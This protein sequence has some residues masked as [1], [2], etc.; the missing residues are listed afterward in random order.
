MLDNAVLHIM[1]QATCTRVLQ[2]GVDVGQLVKWHP[3]F[4]EVVRKS[5]CSWGPAMECH[6]RGCHLL[7]LVLYFPAE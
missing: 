1:H 2:L 7:V 6:F 3:T 5:R 4:C